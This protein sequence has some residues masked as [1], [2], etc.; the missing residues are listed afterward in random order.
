MNQE[1]IIQ[2]QMIEQ[3]GWQ[4]NQQLQLI[5]QNIQEIQEL[6]DSLT[7]IE[8]GESKEILVNLGK[9]IYLPVEMKDEKL[10]V[11]VGRGNYVEKDVPAT[12]EVIDDQMRKLIVGRAEITG[13]LEELQGEIEKLMMKVNEEQGKEDGKER[14]NNK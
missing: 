14:N 12:K 1:Q 2:M 8:V 9:K 4:L 5:E 11:E 3:E 7:E 10:I 13:R 6:K